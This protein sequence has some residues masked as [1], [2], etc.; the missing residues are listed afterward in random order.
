MQ[1]AGGPVLLLNQLALLGE[2]YVAR[3]PHTENPFSL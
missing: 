1:G 3:R 2:D